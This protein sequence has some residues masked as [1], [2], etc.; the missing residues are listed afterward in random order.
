MKPSN[1]NYPMVLKRSQA[2]DMCQLTPAGFDVWVRKGIVPT[3]IAGT[4]RWSRDAIRRALSGGGIA[5]NDNGAPMDA[6]EAWE[7][8]NAKKAS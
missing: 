4:R 2:A 7:A 8:Q 5:Q 3:A 6:F 1:D